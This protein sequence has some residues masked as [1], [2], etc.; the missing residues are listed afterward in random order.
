MVAFK[1]SGEVDSEGGFGQGKAHVALAPPLPGDVGAKVDF[2]VKDSAVKGNVTYGSPTLGTLNWTLRP[3]VGAT[4]F[5]V[6]KK[7]K[8]GDSGVS[9]EGSY[10]GDTGKGAAHA[11]GKG[12]AEAVVSKGSVTCTATAKLSKESK[13]EVLSTLKV[14]KNLGNLLDGNVK[15]AKCHVSVG[16]PLAF[17]SALGSSSV[18]VSADVLT[19]EDVGTLR[20]TGTADGLDAVPKA[21]LK[22]KFTLAKVA[23]IV[24]SVEAA[25]TRKPDGAVNSKTPKLALEFAHTFK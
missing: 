10:S 19:V 9:V 18:E 24:A 5:K 22:G 14:A 12:T 2:F 3:S 4:S 23:G 7:V 13:R 17:G 16:T 25:V 21:T 11:L 1:V 6:A 15:G 8:V 20:V